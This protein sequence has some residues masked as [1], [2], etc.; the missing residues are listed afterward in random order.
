[1]TVYRSEEQYQA[2]KEYRAAGYLVK[3][4][5]EITLQ[6]N[7]ENALEA[8]EVRGKRAIGSDIFRIKL[9][10][11]YISLKKNDIIYITTEGNY[12]YLYCD[13]IEFVIRYS[14]DQLLDVI[15]SNN[16]IR[17]HRKHAINL[18]HLAEFEVP[19]NLCRLGEVIRVI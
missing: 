12:C 4:F 19:S 18:N 1:M 8:R 16:F 14:L 15:G 7:V 3:P 17:V 9:K 2:S 5:D 10:K 13:T 11:K 6:S